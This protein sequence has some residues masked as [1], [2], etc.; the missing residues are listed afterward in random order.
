MPDSL[1]KKTLSSLSGSAPET[2][3]KLVRA[4]AGDM[5]AE[6]ATH[7]D[8][9]C[10][11]TMADQHWEMAKKRGNGDP[12]IEIYYCNIHG[13][14]KTVIDVVSDDM[15][16]LVDSI[17]AEINKNKFLIDILVHPILYVKYNK[18]GALQ[19]V[20]DKQTEGAERQSHI[21]VQIRNTLSEDAQQT[22]KKD[23][24][25]ALTD[26]SLANHDWRK[27]LDKL[28]ETSQELAAAKTNRPQQE[29]GRYCAFLD[30]LHNNN[31]TLLG[32]REY[33]FVKKDGKVIGKTIKGESL[34]LLHERVK[35]PYINEIDEGF[36]RNT[37]EI[38][39]ALLPVSV[40][41]T[42]SLSTVHRRV[43]MDAISIQ[44]FDDKGNVIGEKLFLG[45]LTSVTYSRSVGDVPY[46]REKVDEI[47]AMSGFL[48]G[49]H[50]GKA[51]RHT[52]EKYPRDEL[53]QFSNKELL[54][55]AG[56]ILRLQ[57]RQRIALFMRRDM[58]GR[59]ISCL[60]Y[61][62][63][64]RFGTTFRK[65]ITKILE[66]ELN[67]VCSNFYTNM[68]D[69][70][71]ARIMYT[72]DIDKND[73]PKFKEA[74]IEAKIREAGNT[75]PE[76][77]SEALSETTN[78]DNTITNL[79]LKYGE[80]FPVAYTTRYKAKNAVFDIEKIEQTLKTGLLHLDLY[81]HSDEDKKILRLKVCNPDK[82]L[83]LSDVLPILENMDLRAVAELPFEV[84]PADTGKTIWIHDFTLECD[85]VEMLLQDVKA[86]FEEA[87]TK[88]WYGEAESDGLNRLTLRANLNYREVIILRTYVRYLR[89]IG[90]PFSRAYIENALVQNPKIAK[91]LAEMF[92]AIHDPSEK[93][94]RAAIAE[95]HAAAIAKEMDKVESL[96]QDRILRSLAALV[97]CTLRTNF[98]QKAENG[99]PKSY[100]SIK[101]DSKKIADLPEPKPYREIFVYSPRTEA[102]H[103][104]ADKIAR[105]GIRW[106]D[107]HEDFRTEILGLMKAQQVK[108]AVI[109]PMG[110]KGGFIVKRPPPN[111]SE[112]RKALQLEGIECYRILIRGMLDITD[113]LKGVKVMPPKDV[114]RLDGDDPYLVVAA[115]KGTA[116]FS[117]IA[118][119]LSKEYGF[120]LDDAFASGGS[121]GYDHKK[122]GITA[123][124]AWEGIKLHFRQLN[125]NIQTKP[126]DVVGVGDMAGDVFGN[127]MLLSPQI[128]M[129]G[130]FNHM[131]IVCDPTPDPATSF[132]ERKRLFDN[133]LGWDHY[134]AK[135]LSKGGRIYLRTEKTLTLTPEIQKRFDLPKDKVAPNDL[136]KALLKAR[137]DLLYF[138]GIGTYI[139]S[140][141]QTNADVGDKG[142][143][144]LRVDAT[145][146]RAKVIGEG[147]NLAMTQLG[148]I[149]FAEHG[150]KLNTDFMDNS[151][152][153]DTSDHEVNIKILFADIMSSKKDGPSMTVEARNKILAK[154]T[155]EVAAHV[156]LDNYQQTQAISLAE[157]QARETLQAQE[158]FIK[159]LRRTHGLSRTLEGLPSTEVVEQR[160]RQ[161]KGMTRP[162][163]CI[164][165]AYSKITLTE[166]LLA[167]KIPDSPDMQS[168]VI[169]YFPVELRKK[170]EKEIE[171]HRLR[172]E[173]VAMAISNSI[174]NRMGP[175]FIKA[176][177]E[178]T[179]ASVDDIAQAY[180]IVRAIYDLPKLWASIESLDNKVPAEVQL[181]ALREVARLADHA[182][183]WFLNR[184]GQKLN[185]AEDIKNYGAGVERLRGEMDKL[186]T[187]EIQ[188]HTR[189]QTQAAERDGLPKDLAKQIALLPVLSS[190]SDITKISVENKTNLEDTARAY[191]E[192]GTRFHLDWIRQQAGYIATDTHWQAEALS[193]LINN[194]YLCQAGLTVRVLKNGAGKAKPGQSKVAHWLE[195]HA[196]QVTQLDEMFADLRRSGALDL[197]MLVIAEQKL[198]G[199]YEG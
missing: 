158:D 51:L 22:L 57:E 19:D 98:F 33:E 156:L 65:Q 90:S 78:D 97:D 25:T 199:L 191:F 12:K 96:D 38:R 10:F 124:G 3:K 55:I 126:F 133:V 147:A 79:T 24:M 153:V 8:N 168:W 56:D 149:E 76:R 117:D 5:T 179:G 95:K 13:H 89:Q 186:L 192:I 157:L 146:I 163:L 53:F 4:L 91:A 162:E 181:K 183:T 134:D 145:E 43:P 45:L 144:A 100:L 49:S 130:A 140:S 18:D 15:A 109:V 77:L 42:N 129:I 108:N 122:I 82:P 155:D 39:N 123:R 11:Q 189:I 173:I 152:G 14:R 32:Y 105:G 67:G 171:R 114:A 93:G 172:R 137:T 88:V 107:R 180:M 121:V 154:M 87:F 116:N 165:L 118:N 160:L 71:F 151:A 138:G 94:D 143:D 110:A 27:M 176:C 66:Q 20:S 174:V 36:P 17:V 166:S 92:I 104:R 187:S 52:L 48:P 81:R 2:R 111:T 68:D 16:F 169:E 9:A 40:S 102:V 182:I 141:K 190:A 1:V 196:D 85:S 26:V 167:T 195:K 54:K 80:A 177:I 41:K 136:I 30:Y 75:W 23:V 170:Y 70:V 142:N 86:D 64:D 44:V 72:I 46:L 7:F 115:D 164:L 60:V 74:D 73:P 6:E 132:T 69:S 37:Q 131:H 119:A 198:R 50:N 62:P 58:F 159:D 61:V 59:Y 84:K 103:L 21:H 47:V 31:F 197:P 148:R 83:N 194:L 139:K 185:Q 63:R 35:P 113:N 120:W 128:H 112:N 188:E 29:I 161:G 193:G 135:K 106:S 34:G 184:R 28:K 175:T 127:G 178:K 101:L 150:G 125:H 99:E